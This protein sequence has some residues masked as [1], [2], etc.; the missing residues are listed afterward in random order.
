MH[1]TMRFQVS[2]FRGDG[3]TTFHVFCFAANASLCLRDPELVTMLRDVSND[4]CG[5]MH[6]LAF[7]SVCPEA[8]GLFRGGWFY[9]LPIG[10]WQLPVI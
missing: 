7:Y 2:T 5:W 9:C 10:H 8:E 4:L 1:R 3:L 6:Y